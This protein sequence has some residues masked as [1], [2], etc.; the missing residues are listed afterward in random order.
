[1]PPLIAEVIAIGD[2]LTTG[3]RLDT[4]SRWISQQ[5]CDLG[6]TV[7]YHTTV[8]DDLDANIEVFANAADRADVIVCTGGLGPTADD[9]TRQ[10]IAS[11]A[12]VELELHQ[13][14]LEHLEAFFARRG[15]AMTPSNRIQAQFP[16]GSRVIPNP[17]GTAPGIEFRTSHT[18]SPATIFALPGVPAEMKQMFAATVEKKLMALTGEGNVIHHHVVRCFGSGESHIESLLPDIVKRGRDPL[19]GITASG[20]TISLRLTTRGL[21]V[22]HCLE[23][24]AATQATIESA[25]GDLVF[26]FNDDLLETVVTRKLKNAN[27]Q[28]AIRDAGLHGDVASMLLKSGADLPHT[29][30]GNHSGTTTGQ[31]LT[32]Q[33][34]LSE[35]KKLRERSAGGA[36]VIGLLDQSET[37]TKSDHAEFSV[38]LVDEKGTG[39]AETFSYSGH[40]A[41]RQ[42]IACKRVLN[43]LRLH[44]QADM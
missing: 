11:M 35:A 29:T 16:N 8:G 36:L 13:D 12:G 42:I 39:V 30:A 31:L 15:R 26:G 2:E 34:V 17:E 24:M 20:G 1:M 3:Y 41:T 28:L 22:E 27:T 32:Q 44:F 6:I 10:S 40:S 37:S 25:L 7:M 4:N 23:K 14:Q 5:L 19:V 33:D 18:D 43:F 9:L 21:S 38:A